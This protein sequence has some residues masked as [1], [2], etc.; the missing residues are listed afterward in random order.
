MRAH[1][2]VR[3]EDLSED[4]GEFT[5]EKL[6]RWFVEEIAA[7]WWRR[8]KREELRVVEVDA[9]PRGVVKRRGLPPSDESSSAQPPIGNRALKI[10][11]GIR[12]GLRMVLW[13]G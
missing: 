3:I 13:R 5:D 12:P 10:R 9:K 8:T 6:E 1:A 11:E 7:P 2:Q 4:F